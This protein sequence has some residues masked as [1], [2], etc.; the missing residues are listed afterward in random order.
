M[1]EKWEENEVMRQKWENRHWEKPVD[2]KH[3]MMVGEKRAPG[4]F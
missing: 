2:K 3:V 4:I 1:K